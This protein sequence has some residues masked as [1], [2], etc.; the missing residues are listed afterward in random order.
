MTKKIGILGFGT[1]GKAVYKFLKNKYT[2]T[3]VSISIYDDNLE[4]TKDMF[5]FGKNSKLEDFFERVELLVVSPGVKPKHPLYVYAKENNIPIKNDTNLFIEEWRLRGLGPVVGV[6]GSNGKST[7]VTLLHK[8]IS[9]IG[10]GVLLGGNIGDS[11]LDF[12][13]DNKNISKNTIAILELS[14]YQLELWNSDKYYV[15]VALITNITD[16][17]L[18]RYD[19]S[20]IEYAKTKFNLVHSVKTKLVTN[21][22]NQGINKYILPLVNK[23]TEVYP[24][25]LEA[26]LHHEHIEK[27]GVYSNENGDLIL[28]KEG[29]EISIFEDKGKSGDRKLLG[30]HNLYN[31][32]CIIQ[33]LSLLEIN[34]EETYKSLRDFK[35][36]EHRIEFVTEKGGVIYINDSKATSP[37]ALMKALDTISSSGNDKNIVLISGGDSK[38]VSYS[39]LIDY[40]REF[41][42]YLILLPGDANES[43]I[44]LAAEHDIEYQEVSDMK[45]AVLVSKANSENGDTVLLSPGTS[46]LNYFKNFEDR[47]DQ[48]K[49]GVYLI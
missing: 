46:S 20:I 28:V 41:V 26:D 34:V 7:I 48:F 38:G 8:A 35:G 4:S 5:V 33:I 49:E 11:P 13:S 30:L 25:S 32:A 45:E 27:S 31:I 16:N 2:E 9:D 23:K 39:S 43:F 17:H 22:D 3:E 15:D 44:S 40:F 18:D 37:D 24:I 12:F 14:S 6:T 10:K 42:K 29:K 1:T 19:G 47:G 36:L 21:I